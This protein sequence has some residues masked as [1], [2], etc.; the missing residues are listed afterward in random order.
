MLDST[1]TE[2]ALANGIVGRVL[3]RDV[4]IVAGKDARSYLQGQ[5]TQDL[6]SLAPGEASE[7]LLLSPQGKLE[8][9]GRVVVGDEELLF[10]EVEVGYGEVA[11]ER[12]KRFKL[13][14]K[15]TLELV[16]WQCVELRGPGALA[17]DF[18]A[19]FTE[20]LFVLPYSF[21]AVVGVDLLG[22]TASLPDGV[23]EGAPEAYEAA[24]IAAGVPYMGSELTEKTIPQE[25][26]IVERTVSFTKG[27][28]T[29]QEL[30]ARIDA[31]GNRVPIRLCG[32]VI[33]DGPGTPSPG[34]ALRLGGKD[35]GTLTSV[36]YSPSRHA[37]IAL[38]YLKREVD[39]P[40]ELD[41]VTEDGDRGAAVRELP[42]GV[43]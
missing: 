22:P 41:L 33:E 3:E 7:T 10:L 12:L 18:T 39:P 27:C 24:R 11:L 4:V 17:A 43:G 31:R 5:C 20:P 42:L 35:V 21:G 32:V 28:F 9:A 26:G 1:Q 34:D 30:V 16:R 19:D 15:A 40:A 13:R 2:Q 36:G 25:A 29:G 14:V 38:A 23:E 6:G 8:L 37:T